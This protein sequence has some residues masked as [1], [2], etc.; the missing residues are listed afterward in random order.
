MPRFLA[1]YTMKPEAVLAFRELPKAEQDA[2][3]A[4][5]IA[6]WAAWEERN[7]AFIL[8]RGGMVGKTTRVTKDGIAKAVNPFCGYLVVE[9]ENADAAARMFAD[10]PH[11]TVFPGD[12]VDIMP[13]VT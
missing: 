3:D 8:D 5:G 4:A 1:V 2:I 12:G 11:F 9:A 6:E 13:F 7:A 10:H